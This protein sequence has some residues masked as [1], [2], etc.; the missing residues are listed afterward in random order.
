M[1]E[2]Y[3]IYK[4]INFLYHETLTKYLKSKIKL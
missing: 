1:Y 3:S 2:I 4:N